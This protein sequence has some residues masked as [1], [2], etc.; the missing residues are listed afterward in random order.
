LF[1]IGKQ[2]GWNDSLYYIVSLLENA[3]CKSLQLARLGLVPVP[4][5][6]SPTDPIG[7]L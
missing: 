5:P 1:N 3:L 6:K 7:Y 2:E 4:S